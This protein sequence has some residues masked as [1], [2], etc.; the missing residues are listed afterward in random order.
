MKTFRLYLTCILSLASPLMVADGSRIH[1]FLGQGGWQL[2]YLHFDESDL[3]KFLTKAELAAA[4]QNPLAKTI[5]AGGVTFDPTL[6][7]KPLVIRRDL[8]L[9]TALAVDG[10]LVHKS[11][12]NLYETRATLTPGGDYVPANHDAETLPFHPLTYDAD[13]DSRWMGASSADLPGNAHYIGEPK[14]PGE[15]K[16]WL[17]SLHRYRREI[18]EHI[19][20]QGPVEIAFGGLRAW[21]RMRNAFAKPIDLQPGEPFHIDVEACWRE[22]NGELVLALDLLDRKSNIN[23]DWS[24]VF[25]TLEIP[26]DG[27]WHR[28]KWEGKLPDFDKKANWAKLIFGMDATHNRARGTVQVREFA[29]VLCRR[30]NDG[31]I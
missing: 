23:Q 31:H 9:V 24:T 16:A 11:K 20:G 7:P 27:K 1:I 28:L 6:P 8:G 29:L 5:Q 30:T 2:L 13:E 19:H 22:G 21:V 12:K 4:V 25:S 15:R 17:D 18:R 26:R 14:R 10:R 3:S